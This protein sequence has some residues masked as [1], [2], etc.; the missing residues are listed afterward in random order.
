MVLWTS[1]LSQNY[2][3]FVLDLSVSFVSIMFFC[4]FQLDALSRENDG[5][6]RQLE[7]ERSTRW[8][9][10]PPSCRRCQ[11]FTPTPAGRCDRYP[12]RAQVAGPESPG[13]ELWSGSSGAQ[14]GIMG[15]D[16][17]K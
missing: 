9:P 15:G 2:R 7:E 3:C 1:H 8:P 4:L 13:G 17:T 14:M 5:L 11:I 6:R 16:Q 10:A 12:N